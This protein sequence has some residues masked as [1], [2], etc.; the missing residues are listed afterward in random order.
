MAVVEVDGVRINYLDL[1]TGD[2]PLVLLHAFPLRAE[3][4]APQLA[5]LAA[6]HRVIAPDLKGFG[7]SD[8]PG[9]PAEYTMDRYAD[10]VAGILE[11]ADIGRA[12]IA[13]LSMGGYVAFSFLRLHRERVAGLVLADTRAAS[14]GTEARE[15]RTSQQEQIAAG[16][17]EAV[18]DTLLAGL[19]GAHSK[20]HRPALVAHVRGL[21]AAN[22][23]EGFVGALEAMKARPDST[24]DLAGIDVPTL[25][26][27]GEEDALSPPDEVARFQ[28]EIDGSRLVVLPRAGHLSNL[29]ASDEFDSALGDFLDEV[30]AAE[31]GA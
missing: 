17:I 30:R 19:L 20:E 24:P 6:T 11:Q 4:W 12:V 9:D 29:E 26:L 1:G 16:G 14:D 8:A 25:V 31:A 18:I 3:Q 23:P 21:M 28:A 10:E 13:G 7:A 27:V 22:P 5:F 15:R 2:L